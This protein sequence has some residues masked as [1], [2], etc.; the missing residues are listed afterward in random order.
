[1]V[2]LAPDFQFKFQNLVTIYKLIFKSYI[3]LN[4]SSFLERFQK[5]KSNF[6]FKL[7][8]T[9]ELTY[10]FIVSH[11]SFCGVNIK[12]TYLLKMS[13]S[14]RMLLAWIAC[15]HCIMYTTTTTTRRRRRKEQSR[16][17]FHHSSSSQY[18]QNFKSSFC[19]DYLLPKN[20]KPK[21]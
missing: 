2:G 20:Y 17:T 3:N 14:S 21:L 1:M 11:T 19:A 6:I 15:L 8:A 4:W 5:S 10:I 18:H 16:S 9:K 12:H 13:L 7:H